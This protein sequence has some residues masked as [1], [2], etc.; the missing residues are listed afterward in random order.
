MTA[1]YNAHQLNMH[2][3]ML[4]TLT[5]CLFAANEFVAKG[6]TNLWSLKRC[7]PHLN[8]CFIL[9]RSAQTC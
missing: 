9:T 3:M 4:I 5:E 6:E 2:F 7:V 1:I 8:K